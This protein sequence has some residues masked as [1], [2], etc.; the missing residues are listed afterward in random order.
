MFFCIGQILA[1]RSSHF[2]NLLDKR[3][4]DA[5]KPGAEVV[6]KE[7]SYAAVHALLRYCYKPYS[8]VDLSA[9]L[10]REIETLNA[11]LLGVQ[12]YVG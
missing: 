11:D 5:P 4:D 10:L 12:S 6:L 2:R 3:N 9:E 7:A 8:M 1:L